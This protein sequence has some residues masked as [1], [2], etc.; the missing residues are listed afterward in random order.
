MKPDRLKGGGT[1]GSVG[2]ADEKIHSVA[3]TSA[4]CR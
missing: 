4:A 1:A 2:I 3:L